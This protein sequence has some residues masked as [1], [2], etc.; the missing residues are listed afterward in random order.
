MSRRANASAAGRAAG[1]ACRRSSQESVFPPRTPATR[2]RSAT[3][4]NASSRGLSITRN[5][6]S[7]LLPSDTSALPAS[8]QLP[9]PSENQYFSLRRTLLYQLLSI[10]VLSNSTHFP[11]PNSSCF[12]CSTARLRGSPFVSTIQPFD[13]ASLTCSTISFYTASYIWTACC[14]IAAWRWRC[15]SRSAS[16]PSNDVIYSCLPHLVCRR[17]PHAVF[18]DARMRRRS[19]TAL[20]PACYCGNKQNANRAQRPTVRFVPI[21]RQCVTASHP[22]GS[23]HNREPLPTIQSSVR[24][25]PA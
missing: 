4:K 15:A 12:W 5:M 6:P 19:K 16:L 10:R 11:A 1:P 3:V 14:L 24:Q 8:A 13:R 18:S 9:Q 2:A 21:V 25:P 22:Q 23:R 17:P 20:D 7:P